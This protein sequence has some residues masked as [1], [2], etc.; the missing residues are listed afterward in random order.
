MH[1]KMKEYQIR[2]KSSLFAVL[3]A[4]S[5]LFSVDGQQS[6]QRWIN[7]DYVTNG[8]VDTGTSGAHLAVRDGP[9]IGYNLVGR[10]PHGQTVH[11][12]RQQNN[13]VILGPDGNPA[14]AAGRWV[15]AA[16]IKNGRVDT[17]S[18]GAQL[19]VRSG[20]G[21]E[22][23]LVD[24]LSHGQQVR[25]IRHANGWAE[26]QTYGATPAVTKPVTAARTT[27]RT[28]TASV[29]YPAIAKVDPI[30]P[31][32]D[33]LVL[34][35]TFSSTAFALPESNGSRTDNLSGRWVR[36]SKTPWTLSP[37]GGN[38][39]AY[40]RALNTLH[41][42]RLLYLARDDKRSKGKYVL[43]F[44]Y[45]LT[46]PKDTLAVKVF[47]SD[48]DILVGTVGG[49][50][51]MNDTEKF[52]DMIELPSVPDWTSH[53]VAVELGE[54]YNFVYVLFYGTGAGNTGLDN[55]NLFPQRR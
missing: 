5:L 49:D 1:L 28:S 18:S 22:H 23:D 32:V 12:I 31:P 44:D 51:R 17:G 34:N 15:N 4:M 39:G 45:V 14:A 55:V 25:T 19:A 26:V 42:V 46:H 13:W 24:R 30:R 53:S 38:L 9:G 52:P 43:Q 48:S 20:P 50:F 41:P 54:G 2:P 36:S 11:I 10:L 6:G 3:I 21:I 27:S 7:S 37:T 8:R 29:P 33:N 35:G 47:V 40:A 16:Y